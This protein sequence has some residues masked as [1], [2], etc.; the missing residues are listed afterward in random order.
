LVN[1]IQHGNI[2]VYYI[3]NLTGGVDTFD[4]GERPV[5]DWERGNE[6]SGSIEGGELLD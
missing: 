2:A 3:I 6:P 5:A 4:S 1:V